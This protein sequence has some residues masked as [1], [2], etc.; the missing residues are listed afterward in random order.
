MK[1]QQLRWKQ[2]GGTRDSVIMLD[3]YTA[4][5]FPPNRSRPF[6]WRWRIDYRSDYFSQ[7]TLRA[8]TALSERDAKLKC[9]TALAL[10]MG[11]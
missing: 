3:R 4:Y 1:I 8:G 11:E 10:L 5:C 7:N 6:L 2:I 9:E